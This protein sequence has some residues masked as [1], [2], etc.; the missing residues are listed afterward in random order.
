MKSLKE[1]QLATILASPSELE[2]RERSLPSLRMTYRWIDERQGMV[3]IDLLGKSKGRGQET[4][5][6]DSR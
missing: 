4:V 5:F 3:K 6:R 1:T 2:L